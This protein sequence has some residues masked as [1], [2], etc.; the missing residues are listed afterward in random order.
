[1]FLYLH[2]QLS[3]NK[4]INCEYFKYSHHGTKN[5]YLRSSNRKLFL[6]MDL[7]I[8]R[9]ELNLIYATRLLINYLHKKILIES[10]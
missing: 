6:S 5:K 2:V 7:K 3:I 4:S 8:N 9:D 10:N 1:M